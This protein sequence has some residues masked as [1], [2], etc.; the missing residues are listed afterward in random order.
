MLQTEGP[1]AKAKTQ[2][3]DMFCHSKYCIECDGKLTE[4]FEQ[5]HIFEQKLKIFEQYSPNITFSPKF[6]LMTLIYLLEL[7]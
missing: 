3:W 4:D 7:G 5:R 1:R 6:P 2:I